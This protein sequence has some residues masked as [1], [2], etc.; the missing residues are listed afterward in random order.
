MDPIASSLRILSSPHPRKTAMTRVLVAPL[1]F[2]LLIASFA[3]AQPCDPDSPGLSLYDLGP[4]LYKQVQGGLYP[5]GS[6]QRPPAHESAGLALSRAIVPLGSTGNP[7]PNGSVVLISIGFSNMIQEWKDGAVGEPDSAAQA[8]T[9][10]ASGWQDLGLVNRKLAVVNGAIGGASAEKWAS[11]PP[12]P[13]SPPWKI[14]MYSLSLSGL[15]RLQVQIACVKTAHREPR[16]CMADDGSSTGDAGSLAEDFST[17]ARNLRLMFPNIKLAYFVSR[18]YGG[19]ALSTVNPE[20]FAFEQ[21]FGIKWMVESQIDGTGLFGNLNFDPTNG[22]PVVAP[23]LSYGPYVWSNGESANGLGVHW[24][25]EDFREDDRTHPSG[26]G[27]DNAS[28]AMLR[29]FLTDSTTQPWFV[30]PQADID[31]D[32]DVDLVDYSLFQGCMT[33]PGSNTP[34]P[35]QG[36]HQD[37]DSDIDLR[38][39][40]TFQF[41]FGL[42][43]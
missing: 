12:D 14:P 34:P 28:T 24:S 4:G 31:G 25:L 2:T 5:G 16:M 36:A 42:L 13:L 18:S 21:G 8:F 35:C 27:V 9:A 26:R 33:G 22:Q 41:A 39:Y 20:P 6:N 37:L 30:D 3:G 32:R 7:S 38:D 23:W 1:I 11:V 43:N 29:F 19:Y 10:K 17:M 40:A 15:T